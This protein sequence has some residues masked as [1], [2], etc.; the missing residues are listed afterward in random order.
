[1]KNARNMLPTF[2][3]AKPGGLPDDP[4]PSVYNPSNYIKPSLDDRQPVPPIGAIDLKGAEHLLP[5]PPSSPCISSRPGSGKRSHKASRN[6]S[7]NGSRNNSNRPTPESSGTGDELRKGLN[8]TGSSDVS[9]QDISHH[10]LLAERQKQLRLSPL[11]SHDITIGRGTVH[12]PDSPCSDRA[13][14]A[15]SGNSDK[16]PVAPK[17]HMKIIDSLDAGGEILVFPLVSFLYTI[18]YS[19]KI[20]VH[21][22]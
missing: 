13:S 2:N 7:R 14:S 20:I 8:N 16:S 17:L 22:C 10:N 15:H 6:S 1:M 9:T 11:A 3:D 12:S 4:Y 19:I 5:R 21:N 18:L